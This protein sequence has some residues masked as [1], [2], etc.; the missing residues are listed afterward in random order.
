MTPPIHGRTAF[1]RRSK[2]ATRLATVATTAAVLGGCASFSPDG[3]FG[4]VQQTAKDRLGKDLVRAKSDADHDTIAKRV[5][6]LLA[7]PLTVDDAVQIALLNNPEIGRAH[8]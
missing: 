5:A 1:P 2:L 4:V 7:T 6:E 3:G 8:V